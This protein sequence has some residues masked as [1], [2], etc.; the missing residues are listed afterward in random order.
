MQ[1][2]KLGVFDI[3]IY[4]NNVYDEYDKK[5]KL[6]WLILILIGL[7]MVTPNMKK[8]ARFSFRCS[9]DKSQVE[10]YNKESEDLEK[11]SAYEVCSPDS[12]CESVNGLPT[13]IPKETKEV[14]EVKKE[15]SY[16]TPLLIAGIIF[17]LIIWKKHKGGT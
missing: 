6:I 1:V 8:E 17:L 2:C 4:G 14:K 9:E 3:Y 11:F 5:M 12:M 10:M 13:C 16:T 7:M 15:T